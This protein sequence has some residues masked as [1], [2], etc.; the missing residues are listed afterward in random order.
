MSSVRLQKHR[1]NAALVRQS[2][3]QRFGGS[4]AGAWSLE[5]GQDVV[6]AL[7]SRW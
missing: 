6:D 2:P 7:Q 1:G 3:V 5:V 4:V